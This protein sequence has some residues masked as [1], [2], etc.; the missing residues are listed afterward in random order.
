YFFRSMTVKLPVTSNLN[1]R[2]RPEGAP[3]DALRVTAAKRAHALWLARCGVGD[4]YPGPLP[5][6]GL[7]ATPAADA[8]AG[9]VVDRVSRLIPIEGSPAGLG[10]RVNRA[11][12][13]AG[14]IGAHCADV[15]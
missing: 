13:H 8:P 4:N 12:L 1:I 2:E 6:A 15:G 10:V 9:I 5:G 11:R 7:G 14:G 3:L